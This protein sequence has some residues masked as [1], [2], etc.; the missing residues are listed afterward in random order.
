MKSKLTRAPQIC[1]NSP[2][3]EQLF[4][5][6]PTLVFVR[7]SLKKNESATKACRLSTVSPAFTLHDNVRSIE[8][9]EK[10]RGARIKRVRT[11]IF[12]RWSRRAHACVGILNCESVNLLVFVV[13]GRGFRFCGFIYVA[14]R[15]FLVCCTVKWF[16][17]ILTYFCNTWKYCIIF[18]VIILCSGNALFSAFLCNKI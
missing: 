15:K 10:A 14:Y 4:W 17:N 11:S 1:A 3:N 7:C 16:F 8:S 12:I 9:K 13:G 18:C 5:N 6:T 2:F